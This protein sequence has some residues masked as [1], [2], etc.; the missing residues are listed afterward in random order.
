MEK[1]ILYPEKTLPHASSYV[2]DKNDA[3]VVLGAYSANAKIL[4]TYNKKYFKTKEILT[5]L[6]IEVYTP[7]EILQM[8]RQMKL[9]KQ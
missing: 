8:V 2:L 4:C 5:K 1:L 6:K 9:P 7:A 3:H